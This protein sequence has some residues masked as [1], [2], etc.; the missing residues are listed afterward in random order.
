MMK[1]NI[2]ANLTHKYSILCS[3]ILLNVLHNLS[4]TVSLPWQHS[5]FQTSPILQ[6]FLATFGVPFS[7]LQMVPH[8][9]GATSIEICSLGFVALFKVFQAENHL[10][11]EIKW[12]ETGK[13]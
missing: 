5:G 9:H 3:K 7:Y 2:S 11:I 10:H 8:I 1:K 4:A 12:M 13:E 6:A